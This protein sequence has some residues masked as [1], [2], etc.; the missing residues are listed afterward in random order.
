MRKAASFLRD[1][2]PASGGGR[3]FFGAPG[4]ARTAVTGAIRP[5]CCPFDDLEVRVLP[6]HHQLLDVQQFKEV[7][8]FQSV[9]LAPTL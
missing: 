1:F 3:F 7:M 2:R 5:E 9:A 4:M 6:G 8:L